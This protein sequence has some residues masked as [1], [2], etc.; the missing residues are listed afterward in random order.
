MTPKSRRL[1]LQ[2]VGAI[3]ALLL[4]FFGAWQLLTN[5]AIWSPLPPESPIVAE[6]LLASHYLEGV[7]FTISDVTDS[8]VYYIL[9]NNTEHHIGTFLIRPT[10]E[11]FDGVEWRIAPLVYERAF[12]L[13]IDVHPPLTYLS[14]FKSFSDYAPLE[15]EQ[16]YRIRT[17]IN[18]RIYYHA[19]DVW[20]DLVAEFCL[21]D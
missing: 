13:S 12:V 7:T 1:V 2:S 3:I 20:H 5:E 14:H 21:R 16:L 10:L 11:F 18:A 6:H 8:G 15:P 19:N 17:R 9:F 4:V